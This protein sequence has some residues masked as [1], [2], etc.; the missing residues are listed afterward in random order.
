MTPWFK[1][2]NV[3]LAVPM[4]STANETALWLNSPCVRVAQMYS[5]VNGGSTYSLTRDGGAAINFTASAYTYPNT[6]GATF[7]EVAGLWNKNFNYSSSLINPEAGENSRWYVPTFSKYMRVPTSQAVDA[8]GGYQRNIAP[9]GIGTVNY[10]PNFF[11]NRV[12][13]FVRNGSGSSRRTLIGKAAGDDARASQFIGAPPCVVY[14]ST[15]IVSP[16]ANG[17]VPAGAGAF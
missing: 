6:S 16:V 13:L 7:V 8:L 15:A 10:N 3:P 1:Y 9:G 4:P 12:D 17:D 11:T 2:N 5:F 14:Q